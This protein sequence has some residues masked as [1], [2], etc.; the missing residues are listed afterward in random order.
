MLWHTALLL[1]FATLLVLQ[2]TETGPQEAGWVSLPSPTVPGGT[3]DALA[4]APS[5][6]DALYALVRPFGGYTAADSARLFRSRDASLTWQHVYTF[7]PPVS[8][9]AVDPAD[10]NVIYIGRLDELLHSSDGGLS[11][12]RLYTMGAAIAVPIPRL[13]YTAGRIADGDATC[14]DGYFGIARSDNAGVTWR[15]SPIGCASSITVLAAH[16]A[17][18]DLVYAGGSALEGKM[19]LLLRSRDGGRS[20]EHLSLT[21]FYRHQVYSLAIDPTRPGHLLASDSYGL[22]RSTDEGDTWTELTGAVPHFAW[23]GPRV[24]ITNSGTAFATLTWAPGGMAVYRSDDGGESWWASLARLPRGAYALVSDPQQPDRLYAG[25]ADFGIY[26]STNGGGTWQE[27][28]DG[29]RTPAPIEALAVALGHLYAGSSQGRGGLFRS[30]DGGLTWTAV[31]T[32]TPILTVAV[33]PVSPTV[34][35]AG[36]PTGFYQTNDGNRWWQV[37]DPQIQVED[38]TFTPADPQRPYAAGH[39][40]TQRQGYVLRYSPPAPPYMGGWFLYPVPGAVEVLTVA[41][42]PWKPELVYA[43]GVTHGPWGRA[44]AIYRSRD[45]GMTWQEV[46]GKLYGEVTELLLDARWPEVI[47]AGTT[48]EG[49]Y[50][51]TDYGDTWEQWKTGLAGEANQIYSMAIGTVGIPYLATGDGVYRWDVGTLSW[52]PFGLQGQ[53]IWAILVQTN[54][55]DSLL[56]GTSQG[57]WLTRLAFWRQHFPVAWLH[58]HR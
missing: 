18:P 28:N 39:D 55:T 2:G 52:L 3:V 49:V 58:D 37:P 6:P 12:T 53:P 33:S 1:L 32:D 38:I 15:M 36:S 17:N 8:A 34:A 41:A 20:W 46:S 30:T 45:G 31:I 11:W 48:V 13:I 44:G 24:I 14:S 42:D 35:V 25:L 51:S 47:Y 10:A 19:P 5:T 21:S 50:R 7:T 23:K 27:H 9:L 56:A 54:A 4:I 40:P 57:L 16:P 26:R 22:Y 43:G 29:I